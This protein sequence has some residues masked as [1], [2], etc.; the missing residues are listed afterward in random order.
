[1]ASGHISHPLGL[2]LTFVTT[3]YLDQIVRVRE[4][5]KRSVY[6]GIPSLDLSFPPGYF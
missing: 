3:N 6:T 5:L 2:A 1:M 4:D